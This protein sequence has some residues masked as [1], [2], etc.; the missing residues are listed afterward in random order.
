VQEAKSTSALNHPNIIHLYDIAEGDGAQ[1]IGMEY[2]AGET[3]R[4]ECF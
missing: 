3:Q 4:N 2:V 1:F